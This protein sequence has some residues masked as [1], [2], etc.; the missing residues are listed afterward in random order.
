MSALPLYTRFDL[1][2][3]VGTISESGKLLL[4]RYIRTQ[5]VNEGAWKEKNPDCTDFYLNELPEDWAWVWVVTEKQE[6][7]GT[8]PKR[9]AKY[10]RNAQNLKCPPEFL[11]ELGNI[12]RSHSADA[13][14]YHFEFVNQIDW[15]DGDYG[16]NG[17]CWWGQYAAARET[18]TSN[19]G[20]AIRFYDDNDEGMGRA[21]IVPMGDVFFLFNGYGFAGDSTLVI[22]RVMAQHLGL[23]YK[24]VSLSNNGEAYNT[25]YINNA[26]GYVIG[27]SDA[28]EGIKSHDFGF[29]IVGNSCEN[30]GRDI[31]DEEYTAP[32]G[33]QY[34]ASCFYDRCN[35]CERCC[36]VYWNDDLTYVED[37]GDYCEHCLNIRFVFCDGCEQYIRRSEGMT[38]VGDYHY[39]NSC[40]DEDFELCP[41][42]SEWKD[43][44]TFV[45]K[46]DDTRICKEC[47]ET[48]KKE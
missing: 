4:I 35:E 13:I 27:A 9:I 29:K 26:S 42:C 47:D 36:E 22:A 48:T 1:Q 15:E 7:V 32:D 28:I 39:C 11:T 5:R 38:L 31:D 2:M 23:S 43:K 6:Y 10:F 45:S 33:T 46:D 24:K 14:S 17:S 44:E 25:L 3:P 8:F 12:A 37:Q 34:C 41:E 20:H 30:C 16:D 40:R 18:L 21:W 19:G